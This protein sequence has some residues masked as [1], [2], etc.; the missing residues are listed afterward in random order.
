MVLRVIAMSVCS[1]AA[2]GLCARA[3][4]ARVAEEDALLVEEA[5]EEARAVLGRAAAEGT[6]SPAVADEAFA[7]GLLPEELGEECVSKA[8]RDRY[9]LLTAHGV[10]YEA[11]W[12]ASTAACLA[13]L[14][15]AGAGT[16]A[17]ATCA[18]A[19]A[20]CWLDS[21]RRL[22]AWPLALG[23]W[24]AGAWASGLAWPWAVSSL[25]ASTAAF[26][27]SG[28]VSRRVRKGSVGLGDDMLLACTLA[29]CGSLP[30]ACAFL[31]ALTAVLA[32][33]MV[34]LRTHGRRGE[35]QP[36]ACALAAAYLLAWAA[37]GA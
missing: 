27:L 21:A 19:L 17:L 16:A 37:V 9:G 12:F 25:A 7:A 35:R 13:G 26:A 30:R 2:A 34:W 24:A 6:L 28:A 31:A 10:P 15:L 36:L 18:L 29:G 11:L 20:S 8:Y 32:V 5:G 33:Q 3:M 23:T 22:A 14:S 4:G 1:A